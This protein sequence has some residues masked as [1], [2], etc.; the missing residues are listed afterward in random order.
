MLASASARSRS[1]PDRMRGGVLAMR[2]RARAASAALIAIGV[3]V[4]GCGGEDA[5]PVPTLQDREATATVLRNPAPSAG[6]R[7]P[8]R[9][10]RN[11]HRV[12]ITVRDLRPGVF[13]Y[14]APLT[15][16]AG[17]V[18]IRLRNAGDTPHK[19]Q[20]W[21]VGGGHTVA[22]ALRVRRPQP[23]WLRAAG[24][25]GLV[26]PGRSASTLQVLRPG[27]YYVA[28]TLD[29]PG[30]VAS[31]TVT[32]D[33]PEA[34]LPKAAARVDALDFK[35]AVAGLTAGRNTIE[36]RNLGSEPHHAF[37]SPIV[38]SADLQ[39]VR[40][41]FSG[42]SFVGAPPVD[43]EATRETVVLEGGDRQVTEVDLDPGRYA[44]I[45]FVRGRAGGPRH[46]ELGML[47]ELEVG[48]EPRRGG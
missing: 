5:P 4:A 16:G 10:G 11:A 45:C 23:D 36:F 24:G 26:S 9:A 8:L 42:R 12:S 20:L 41:F 6:V 46:I 18:E 43:T 15:V 1:E 47:N 32:G 33:E 40:R 7:D 30:Q 38:G 22:E 28:A 31:F 13:R 3:L 17:L 44:V 27:L 29:Q 19:A 37:F 34:S 35:F 14:R 25:V 2:R 48:R 21:R 39:D